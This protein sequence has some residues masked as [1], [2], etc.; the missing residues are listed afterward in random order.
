M[1]GTVKAHSFDVQI[2]RDSTHASY[3]GI[4]IAILA[5]SEITGTI[6]HIASAVPLGQPEDVV[7]H[8]HVRDDRTAPE[9]RSEPGE[10]P[11]RSTSPTISVSADC[12][13]CTRRFTDNEELNEHIA[14][15]LSREAIR[16]AQGESDRSERRKPEP[17]GG[18]RNLKEWWKAGSGAGEERAETRKARRRKLKR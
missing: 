4:T 13:L 3:V 14:W 8:P 18:V 9:A 17:E 7:F 2:I 10:V 12:P 15:C 11:L 16:S 5:T 1:R 6:Q